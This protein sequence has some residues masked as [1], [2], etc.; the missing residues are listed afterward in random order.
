MGLWDT[1]WIPATFLWRWTSTLS[2]HLN[3]ISFN[4][5]NNKKRKH[6]ESEWACEYLFN[7]WWSYRHSLVCLFFP[8]SFFFERKMI[9]WLLLY[10]L[11]EEQQVLWVV[12]PHGISFVV[13]CCILFFFIYYYH[14]VSVGCSSVRYLLPENDSFQS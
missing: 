7:S 8:F 5:N 11:Q 6:F 9:F 12:V 14:G 10:Y 4:N 13:L 1:F 2:P 3:I